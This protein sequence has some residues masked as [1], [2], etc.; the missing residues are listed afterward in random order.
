MVAK[1]TE[2]SYN[3]P[4]MSKL[5]SKDFTLENHQQVY[6]HF[7]DY[8]P[9]RLLVGL[10]ANGL[11]KAYNPE[12]TI[13]DE[14]LKLVEERVES[15]QPLIFASNHLRI[16]DQFVIGAAIE[17]IPAMRE[18]RK[19]GIFVPAKFEYF[20]GG[21]FTVITKPFT[22]TL[23]GVPVFRRKGITPE[24][25]PLFDEATESFI[26]MS[27][28][29]LALKQSMIIFPEGTRNKVDPHKVQKI[30]QGVAKTALL[31]CSEGVSPLIVSTALSYDNALFGVRG[32]ALHFGEAIDP[33][34]GGTVTSITKRLAKNIQ[35]AVDLLAA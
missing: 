26:R 1:N 25:E 7:A 12:V 27:A 2:F 9:S 30:Y 18:A 13:D 22:E 8:E 32:P 4:L 23:G 20:N 5:K 33:A 34:Q 14:T 24:Q 10:A 19:R 29:K 17:A 35:G 16:D 28:Q 6:D 15:E 31:A 21:R 11:R 3:Y